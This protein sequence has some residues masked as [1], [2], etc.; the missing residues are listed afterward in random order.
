MATTTQFEETWDEVDQW[1]IKQKRCRGLGYTNFNNPS[2]TLGSLLGSTVLSVVFIVI[3]LFSGCY[4]RMS[5][6]TLNGEIAFTF[7]LW[8][9]WSGSRSL[10]F[11]KHPIFNPPG[12]QK[13]S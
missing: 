13:V 2:I 8:S 1:F 4:T 6:D 3:A 11:G 9:V 10:T 12:F 5:V 7:S